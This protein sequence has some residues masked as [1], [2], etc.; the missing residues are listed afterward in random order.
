MLEALP[1][2]RVPRGRSVG[3][4]RMGLVRALPFPAA[5][6]GIDPNENSAPRL[7]RAGGLFLFHVRIPGVP[8]GDALY[9]RS[10][11]A[12][13]AKK[14]CE[15]LSDRFAPSPEVPRG[16]VGFAGSG[17][18]DFPSGFWRRTVR[19]RETGFP[20]GAPTRILPHS[21]SFVAFRFP[22]VQKSRGKRLCFLFMPCSWPPP[23]GP[24]L[25]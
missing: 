8:A 11:N 14:N 12:A 20:V 1:R 16:R 19:K 17:A 4:D 6:P 21:G 7:I 10:R 15:K 13:G 22:Q 18:S 2:R 9:T 3:G 25:P 23:R 5:L 24:D